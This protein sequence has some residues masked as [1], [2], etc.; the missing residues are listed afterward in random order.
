M[1]LGPRVG[2]PI[3]GDIWTPHLGVTALDAQG[4]AAWRGCVRCTGRVRSER[5]ASCPEHAQHLGH[6]RIARDILDARA[7]PLRAKPKSPAQA[8]WICGPQVEIATPSFSSMTDARPPPKC[9]PGMH[10][11]VQSY[12]SRPFWESDFSRPRCGLRRVLLEQYFRSVLLRA[13]LYSLS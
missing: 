8:F 6:A 1:S 10:R 13:P 7:R 9:A 5:A 12:Y 11:A 2:R 3:T 4:A